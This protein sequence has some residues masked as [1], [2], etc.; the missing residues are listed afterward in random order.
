MSNCIFCGSSDA[1]EQVKFPDTFTAYQMLQAGSHACKRCHTM[2]TTG[3]YRR[4]C[5]IIKNGEFTEITDVLAFLQNMPQPPYTLYVTK[6]KRKHGW[7]NAV[8][9]PVLNTERFIL[10]VDEEKIFFNCLEFTELT[11]FLNHLWLK[12]LPKGIL[13]GG[14]P[15]AGLIRKYKLT[16]KECI[17]LRDLKSNR[18]WQFI[19][20]FKKREEKR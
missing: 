9:N 8:Q 1:A 4:K 5:F 20:T 12:E 6:Q 19:V 7:I 17:R 3:I 18:M 13:L 14:Y 10:C 15:P 2:F 16:R 11:E